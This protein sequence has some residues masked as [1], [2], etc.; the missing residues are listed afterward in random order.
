MSDLQVVGGIKKLN[1]KNYNTWVT[2]MTSYMQEQD[3][4]EVVNGSEATQPT[5]ED[6][7]DILCKWKIKASKAMFALKTTIKEEMLEHIRDATTPK[8]AWDTF[9]TLLLKKNDT[10]L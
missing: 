5:A 9:A 2:C 7:N 1:K 3:L 6:A 10:R 8:K 4:W